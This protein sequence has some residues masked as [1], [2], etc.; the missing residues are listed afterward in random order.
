MTGEVRSPSRGLLLEGGEGSRGLEGH[1]VFLRQ[2]W[3]SIQTETGVK[4]R[5][6]LTVGIVLKV[7]DVL[8]LCFGDQGLIWL[9]E[10]SP[11]ALREAEADLFFQSA[12]Y[13]C[14]LRLC[15]RNLDI[16]D[17]TRPLARPKRM[18]NEPP[19]IRSISR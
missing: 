19:A 6:S 18:F 7:W 5:W 13:E 17:P 1:R 16:I 8:L 9:W 2:I 3:V 10:S 15:K 11:D 4:D 12:D 14:F